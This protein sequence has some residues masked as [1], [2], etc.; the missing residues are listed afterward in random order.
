[1][2][3][4]VADL[5]PAAAAMPRTRTVRK[6]YTSLAEGPINSQL[7]KNGAPL[8]SK[9]YSQIVFCAPLSNT[10]ARREML[11]AVCSQYEH[12]LCIMLHHLQAALCL[13][14]HILST[15]TE[16]STPSERLSCAAAVPAETHKRGAPAP[17]HH[18]VTTGSRW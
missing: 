3:R 5:L 9:S 7:L 2:A 10:C 11:K 4:E 18:P 15:F 6:D 14:G 16:H 12:A 17:H 1:M 13:H 8:M